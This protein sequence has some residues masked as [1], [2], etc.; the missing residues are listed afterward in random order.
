M[1]RKATKPAPVGQTLYEG[2]TETQ[3]NH[4]S[5]AAQT[6]AASDKSRK[7]SRANA[8]AE[9]KLAGIADPTIQ[10]AVEKAF[11]LSYVAWAI[12]PAGTTTMTAQLL[13]SA[14]IGMALK[15]INSKAPADERKSQAQHDAENAAR[16]A[17]FAIRG[18]CGIASLTPKNV[19]PRTQNAA[20]KVEVSSKPEPSAKLAAPALRSFPDMV[21]HCLMQAQSMNDAARKAIGAGVKAADPAM[22]LRFTG[23]LGAFRKAMLA[24]HAEL[25]ADDDAEDDAA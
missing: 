8:A 23:A 16:Q 13:H 17:L 14:E 5:H 12:A 11:K 1:A 15:G 3:G 25:S 20:D 22:G 10:S 18:L 7:N 21:Q 6:M 4:L 24:L 9:L 2:L 19:A